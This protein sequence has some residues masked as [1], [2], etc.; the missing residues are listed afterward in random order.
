MKHVLVLLVFLLGFSARAEI[1]R[2][3]DN[4]PNFYAT[5]LEGKAIEYNSLKGKNVFLFFWAIECSDCLDEM[6]ALNL[7]QTSY[8]DKGLRVIGVNVSDPP[9]VIQTV[10]QQKNI[11]FEIWYS[12]P[13]RGD[14]DL[15]QKLEEWQGFGDGFELPWAFI[16]GQDGVI[17][18]YVQYFDETS[19]DRIAKIAFS[20]DPVARGIKPGADMQDFTLRTN[21]GKVVTWNDYKGKPVIINF[22]GS[23]CPPCRAEMPKLN[24]L[25]AKYKL[26]GLIVLGINYAETPDIAQKYLGANPIDYTVLYGLNDPM[27]E[28][29]AL[30]NSWGGSGVPWNLFIAKD[31]KISSWIFGYAPGSEVDIEQ[32]I[33]QIL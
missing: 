3:G 30:F 8:K 5:T 22:W 9:N 14:T 32:K 21:D 20:T 27:Q 24:A 12:N 1:L 4:I 11:N 13:I 33:N 6:A 28:T 16:A 26:K 23:W 17:K 29:R 10:V 19:V 7:L 15:T 18:R 25:F 31:G 2:A